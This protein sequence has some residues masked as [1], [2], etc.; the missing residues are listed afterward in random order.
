MAIQTRDLTAQWRRGD[1]ERL[2]RF[3]NATGRGWPGGGWDP[4]TPE[5]VA[6]R[7]R[8]QKLLGAFVAEVDGKIVSFCSVAA[9]PG[10]RD[11]AY[12][13]FL[14]ADP[15]YH[16]RGF[17]KAVLLRAIERVYE[18]GIA[19]VDLHTW[20]GNLKAVPL[21]KKSGFMWNP[22]SGGW[23]VHMQNFTPGARRHP[24]AAGFFRAHDWYATMKRDLSLAPDD[25]KR[26]K[27]RVYPY[28]WEE[29]GDRLRMVYD[30]QSWGLLEIETNDL[31]VGCSLAEEKLVAGLPHRITWQI[32]NR[33]SRPVDVVLLASADE[34]VRI[35]HKEVL[36][37]ARRATLHAEFEIDPA[38]PEKEREPRVPIIRTELIVDGLPI[39]LQA[40]FE[41]RQAVGFDL[42]ADALGL[43]PG[44]PE[45]V[46]VQL[47][48]NLEAP[49]RATARISASG[50]A[51]VHHSTA[52]VRLPARG[53][54]RLPLD[55]EVQEPGSVSL[56]VES[57]VKVGGRTVNPRPADLYAS[58]LLPGDLTGRVE[59]DRVVLE[60]A[61]LRVAIWRQG[62]YAQVLDKIRNRWDAAA[63]PPPQIGP[64][65]AWDDLFQTRCDAHIEREQDRV[66]AVLTTPS[67]YRP[68]VR[69]ERRIALSNTP[70]IAV[71]DTVINGSAERLD[72]RINCPIGL[73]AQGGCVSAP[74]PDGVVRD[75]GNTAGRSLDEH[76]L[77]DRPE[78]WPEGW[79]AAEDR[80]GFVVGALWGRAERIEVGGHW[81]SLH[82]PLPAIEP[83]E[84]A[85]AAPVHLFV[86]DGDFLCVRRWWQVLYGPRVDREQRH[87]ETRRPLEFGLEPRPLVIHGRRA[88]AKLA[89]RS[90]GRLELEG[91]LSIEAPPGLRV[92]PRSARFRRVSG[93]R[94]AAT[95]VEAS[96]SARLPEGGYFVACTARLD[97]AVYHERQPV[98][99]LGD[100]DRSVTV[101]RTGDARE[102]WRIDNGVY[103]LTIA[104]GFQG[105]AISLVREGEE[106]LRSSYPQAGPLS[107]MNPWFGGIQP[108]FEPLGPH[109]LQQERFRAREIARA[110]SQGLSWRGVRVSCA[111]KHERA[112]RGALALDYLL[113]PG[114]SILAVALRTTRRADT[115]GHLGGGLEVYPVL[116]GS[117]LDA[118]VRG[119]ADRRV[120]RLR[121]Q[122]D[123]GVPGREWVIADNE[124]AGQ[125]ALMACRGRTSGTGAHL[126]GAEGYQLNGW[127]GGTHEPRETKEAIF[128][129][130]FTPSERAQDLAEALAGLDG[131]P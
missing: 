104:P 31:L 58:A 78:D 120:R 102:L 71:Q 49:A 81:G 27:V 54:A 10:Q 55:I 79:V 96:R 122:F 3:M 22:D 42:D 80:E 85:A 15:D 67:V 123:G 128:F 127:T 88:P 8:E 101:E 28:E 94:G 108:R 125:A 118:V 60:S 38:I 116:A 100:P 111:P 130:A 50:G 39:T 68:G 9:K 36:K 72:V 61:A 70:L 32:V 18:Q 44:R 52:A 57:E 4:K 11:Q 115:A 53:T 93:R 1:A 107:W 47:W 37:V 43:R 6:R 29:D 23:G 7:V 97:R 90:V 105:C 48:S 77:S 59:R 103:S 126:L 40:G 34:G 131:L 62:G 51:R 21:Y 83:G 19:R 109:E 56:K 110:G 86:G 2:A 12:V 99:V 129:L 30:R 76:R 114:S 16:G 14:T 95:T 45:R 25:H 73:R 119:A 106:L 124:R 117:H 64:P 63:L 121:C 17:G 5:E 84:S 41:V 82:V 113:A 98:I 13:P 69:L 87:P 112:R 20:P 89:A 74:T 91:G 26:G 46:F 75:L 24:V 92:E 33:R 66:A 65:F 35:D